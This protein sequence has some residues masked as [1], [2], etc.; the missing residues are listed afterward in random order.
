VVGILVVGCAVVVMMTV[1][2]SGE[3]FHEKHSLILTVH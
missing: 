3:I 2:D 1:V